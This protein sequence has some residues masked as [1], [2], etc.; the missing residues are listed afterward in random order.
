MTRGKKTN[1][2]PWENLERSRKFI[3]GRREEWDSERKFPLLWGKEKEG[4]DIPHRVKRSLNAEQG[5][6]KN[7]GKKKGKSGGTEKKKEDSQR[8]SGIRLL[9][10]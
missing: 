8:H 5:K 2:G 4:A 7:Q 6:K 3:G 10:L 9:A 1:I